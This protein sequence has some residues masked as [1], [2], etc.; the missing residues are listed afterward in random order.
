M[1]TIVCLIRFFKSIDEL[2]YEFEL[3]EDYDK[4]YIYNLDADSFFD[5]EDDNLNYI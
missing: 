4:E 5:Y 1:E 3:L 2:N